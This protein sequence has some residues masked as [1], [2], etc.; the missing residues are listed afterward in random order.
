[1]GI[2]DIPTIGSTTA[3]IFPT[4]VGSLISISVL[5]DLGLTATY[6]N[7][8]VTVR[9]GDREVMR[10]DRDPKTGLWMLDLSMFTQT[11]SAALAVQISTQADVAAF[12][13]GAFGSPALSTF[14]RAMDNGFIIIPGV[15]AASMRK[16]APNP[17][18]TPFGHLDQTRQGMRSTK[19][20]VVK[21]ID[22]PTVYTH[23]NKKHVI[24]KFARTGRNYMDL[25]GRFPHQSARG[26]NYIMIMYSHDTG[27][28]H[29]ETPASR[30]AADIVSCFKRGIEMFTTGKDKPDIERID[31]ECSKDFRMLCNTLKISI[32]LAPPGQHRTNA[33]E[34]AIRTFKDHF[35]ATLSTTDK[36]FPLELWDEL[37]PQAEITLNLMRRCRSNP[38]ISAFESVRGPFD[39]NKTPIAP[40]GTRVVVHV[41]PS[42]RAS[43]D[44]HGVEGFYVGPALEHYRCF[45]CWIIATAAIRVTDTLSWHPERL[46]MPGSSP[47]EALAAAIRDLTEALMRAAAIPHLATQRQ[48]IDTLT[49][50]IS[51]QLKDLGEMFR[52][53]EPQTRDIDAMFQQDSSTLV[54]A[55]TSGSTVIRSTGAFAPP[56]PITAPNAANQRV[57]THHPAVPP[58]FLPLANAPVATTISAA[59]QRVPLT[60]ATPTYITGIDPTQQTTP[61]TMHTQSPSSPTARSPRAVKQ[62]RHKD[63]EALSDKAIGKLSQQIK[64]C[65]GLQYSDDRD[66]TISGTVHAVMRNIHTRKLYFQTWDPKQHTG[67]PLTSVT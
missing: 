53:P 42:I 41:K 56:S 49:K 50:S 22:D 6:D 39:I 30:T 40:V 67:V 33:A 25:A 7:M 28:I 1:V 15:S 8:F 58:G 62:Q 65:I 21:D 2:L 51:Q 37:I 12:W 17:V 47:I 13:H 18:A 14:T 35:I 54:A 4:L 10:G 27:Y 16:H 52:Q 60:V 23:E 46:Q 57:I 63:F 5:V 55:P 11:H 64:R 61:I 24:V 38:K 66:A 59:K 20:A 43:W 45:R 44:T 3:H 9:Q 31:N 19:P 34:R 29:A 48:P 26:A 32:E 36:D